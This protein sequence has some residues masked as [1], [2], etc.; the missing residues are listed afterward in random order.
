[1]AHIDAK[2]KRTSRQWFEE[3]LA[4]LAVI[5]LPLFF[6]GKGLFAYFSGD[7]FM[8]LY[9][10]WSKPFYE[11]VQ[12]NVLYYSSFYRP[13]GGLVYL[14]LFK[15]FGLNPLPFR[16]VCFGLYFFNLFLLY[17]LALA[18]SGSKEAA[19]LTALLGSHHAGYIDY[20]TNT[21]TIYD[22][23]C[24]TFFCGGLFLHINGAKSVLVLLSFICALNS[25]EM[26]VTFPVIVLAYELIF[27]TPELKWQPLKRWLRERGL[28]PI[29]LGF[30]L[31]PYLFSKLSSHSLLSSNSDY[32]MHLTYSQYMRNSLHYLELA[33]YQQEGWATAPILFA[34][35]GGTFLAALA[36]RSRMLLFC[37]FFGLVTPLPI[38]FIQPRGSIFVLYIPMIGYTMFAG[39]VMTLIHNQLGPVKRWLVFAA[40]FTALAF[41]H[42]V[43]MQP[44]REVSGIRQTAGQLA[45]FKLHPKPGARILLMDD[46]LD[47][48]ESLWVPTFIGRLLYQDPELTVDRLKAMEKKP[49][50]AEINAY[51]FVLIYKLGR[52]WRR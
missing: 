41:W 11:T 31:F 30:L 14:S 8:N 35:I 27:H 10:Y 26:A 45:S 18:L 51:D 23:L 7:D 3:V 49:S 17:R 46:A 20:Y 39:V 12:A 24:F 33:I 5:I 47:T 2:R 6:G 38:I 50:E 48:V 9:G 1:M 16:I 29:A 40:A 36:L 44:L 37:W 13:L 19:W 4:L 32:A 25:K 34:L 43:N 28:V 21:G 15:V 42:T 52:L 22:L